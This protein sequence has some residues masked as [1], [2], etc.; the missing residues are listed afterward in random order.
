MNCL[1]DS[2]ILMLVNVAP[3][4]KDIR[5]TL[6][7]LS[8]GESARAAALVTNGLTFGKCWKDQNS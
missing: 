6:S 4:Q 3:V 7:S 1:G 5:A 8:F 2:K